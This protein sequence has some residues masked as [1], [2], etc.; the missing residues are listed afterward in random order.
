MCSAGWNYKCIKL[1]AV[2]RR[3]IITSSYF[4]S[5]DSYKVSHWK[6]YPPGTQY[7]YSFLD[8]S[9]FRVSCQLDRS[10][11]LL[12]YSNPVPSSNRTSELK[13]AGANFWEPWVRQR[14][15]EWSGLFRAA[16]TCWSLQA[17]TL[18]G[19]PRLLGFVSPLFSFKFER[20][21]MLF[22]YSKLEAAWTPVD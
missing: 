15:M 9:R 21:E 12:R 7:V 13:H 10:I 20:N 19:A 11:G 16:A 2:I 1:F 4:S 14:W 3:N 8:A 17:L 6:Q 18:P 5:Q 22:Y